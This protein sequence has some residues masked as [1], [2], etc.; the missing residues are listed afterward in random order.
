MIANKCENCDF[1]V[2]KGETG[3]AKQAKVGLCHRYPP[4]ICIHL[5]PRQTQ[6]VIGGSQQIGFEPIDLVNWPTTKEDDFCGE[7]KNDE[8]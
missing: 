2:R 5:V 4:T 7:F 3:T 1:W 6:K 8:S